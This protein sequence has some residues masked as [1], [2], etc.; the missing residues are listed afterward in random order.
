[1]GERRE[2]NPRMV[3][4]QSTA[5]IHLATSALRLFTNSKPK[6]SNHSPFFLSSKM[7]YKIKDN[8]FL[9]FIFYLKKCKKKNS[10]K[11]EKNIYKYKSKRKVST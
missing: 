6:M 5:L 2:L 1:M 7:K 11:I 9:S 8:G 3:D 4:S 10:K